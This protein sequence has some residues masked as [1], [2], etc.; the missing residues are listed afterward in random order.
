VNDITVPL[1]PAGEYTVVIR[2]TDR[3]LS[4]A[5]ITRSFTVESRADRRGDILWLNGF[6]TPLFPLPITSTQPRYVATVGGGSRYEY[7]DTAEWTVPA[8]FRAGAILFEAVVLSASGELSVAGDDTE[9]TGLFAFNLGTIRYAPNDVVAVAAHAAMTADE[10]TGGSVEESRFRG[11]L[12]V[13]VQL[14]P[15]RLA[16]VPGI[17]FD[18]GRNFASFERVIPA[19]GGAVSVDHR[20]LRA[21][22]AGELRWYLSPLRAADIQQSYAVDLAYDPPT[23]PVAVYAALV[24]NNLQ[25]GYSVRGEAGVALSIR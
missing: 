17:R 8:Y 15:V 13:S 5:P 3:E 9:P 22:L 25:E 23:S 24:L 14:G 20:A 16:T 2:G 6:G 21:T 1:V 4:G 7:I 10:I 19:A 11:D 12:P 18:A